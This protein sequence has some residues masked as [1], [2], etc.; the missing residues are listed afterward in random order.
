[1]GQSFE[2]AS[3]FEARLLGVV[4][5][6]AT[7]NSLEIVIASVCFIADDGKVTFG[8]FEWIG[9]PRKSGGGHFNLCFQ[10]ATRRRV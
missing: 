5:R 7:L 2:R 4:K 10:L 6:T 8:G 9:L 3:Q 1:M